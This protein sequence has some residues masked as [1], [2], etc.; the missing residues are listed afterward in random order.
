M[1][2]AAPSTVNV[3][4][5]VPDCCCKATAVSCTLAVPNGGRYALKAKIMPNEGWVMILMMDGI[6]TYLAACHGWKKSLVQLLEPN[7]VH[8]LVSG[9]VPPLTRGDIHSFSRN[10]TANS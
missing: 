5:P 4:M 1:V 9:L 2:L 10:F 6:L 3:S 7:W 8:G